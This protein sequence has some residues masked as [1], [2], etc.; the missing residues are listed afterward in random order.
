[1]M[2]YKLIDYLSIYRNFDLWKRCKYFSKD[3]TTI[4]T[5]IKYIKSHILVESFS[6]D[7][8]S[9]VVFRLYGWIGSY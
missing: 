8:I 3:V 4:K 2:I 9:A 7:I 5:V 1:M 6:I